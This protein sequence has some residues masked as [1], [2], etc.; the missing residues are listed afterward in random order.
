MLRFRRCLHL[1]L[2]LCLLFSSAAF[3]EI[4]YK[5]VETAN[6]KRL[7]LK[8]TAS[9]SPLP[10][11]RGVDPTQHFLVLNNRAPTLLLSKSSVSGG[12]EVSAQGAT[13]MRGCHWRPRALTLSW[14]WG[15]EVQFDG[16][17]GV[18]VHAVQ[19]HPIKLCNDHLS[20]FTAG[21]IVCFT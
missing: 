8:Q 18:V 13:I 16:E 11:Q 4:Y 20:V 6:K 5:V 9:F 3:T 17:G 14:G 2:S 19:C 7:L 1:P 21:K 10:E 15:G 12:R